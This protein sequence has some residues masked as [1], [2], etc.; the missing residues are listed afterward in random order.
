MELSSNQSGRL[1]TGAFWLPVVLCALLFGQIMATGHVHEK[2]FDASSDTECAICSHT[3]QNDDLDVP[4]SIE[5]PT[6][7]YSSLWF[8]PTTTRQFSSA[9]LEEKARGPPY[10]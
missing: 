1:F 2:E 4:N 7:V 10:S 5:A 3:A 9:K 8:S 6:M